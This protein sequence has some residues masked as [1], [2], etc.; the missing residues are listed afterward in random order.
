MNAPPRAFA[1]LVLLTLAAGPALALPKFVGRNSAE[2]LNV[3]AGARALG[4]GDALAT[5]AEGA[6]AMY[7]N[8]GGLMGAQ[9]PEV[10]YSHAE[11]NEFFRHDHVAYAQPVEFL[12]GSV[13][14]A[15]TIWTMDELDARTNA[16]A[17][18]GKFA[19]YST[20]FSL[21]YARSFWENSDMPDRDREF[22]QDKYDFP[23]TPRP[24]R[25]ED[26]LWHGSMRA[27]L[28]L[29]VVHESIRNHSATALAFDAGAQYHPF[30]LSGLAL[31][32]AFKNIGTRPSFRNEGAPLP[33]EMSAG[34]AYDVRWDDKR[35]LPVV[36]LV[37]PYYGDPALRLGAEF[38]LNAGETTRLFFRAGY[39]TVSARH[40]NAASGATVGVGF[41]VRRF[42]ADFAFQ[43]MAE[44]GNALRMSLHYRF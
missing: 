33:A 35:V 21:G 38:S 17:D 7:W 24:L 9:G 43:P 22:F 1:V 26:P 15:A 23:W 2:F 32:L 34:A 12:G 28:A 16:N 31:S 36:E 6:D 13:G 11:M 20:A 39:K 44:L 19:P 40:L 10:G 30:Q 37:L 25:E 42:G 8:P 5:V 29:K 3:G 41:V 4:M 18:R 27:G 14:A